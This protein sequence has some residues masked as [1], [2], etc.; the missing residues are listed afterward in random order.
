MTITALDKV[1]EAVR[2]SSDGLT[3]EEIATMA[4][5]PLQ[6]VNPRVVELLDEG[7]L[8]EAGTF[9]KTARGRNAKVLVTNAHMP[10]A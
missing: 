7:S 6:T 3:R 1:Y 4:D 9:R 5:L 2:A 8:S 10:A